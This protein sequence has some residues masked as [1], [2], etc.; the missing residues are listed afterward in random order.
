M[1]MHMLRAKRL[2]A[3]KRRR[4]ARRLG[5]LAVLPFA[6]LAIGAAPAFAA[7]LAPARAVAASTPCTPSTTQLDGGPAIT[8]CGPA[9][10][11]LTIGGKS[12]S[13][14]S[15][16]C[17]SEQLFQQPFTLSLGTQAQGKTGAGAPGN[18][19]KPF[20]YLSL[21][22][23]K[24][25]GVLTDAYYGGKKITPGGLIVAMGTITASGSSKGT[26]KNAKGAP[27]LD[28]KPFLISGSWN[29]HGVFEKG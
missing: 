11:T 24:S 8:S 20:F 1:T 25:Q 3:V 18:A 27:E 7:S 6:V 26:F 16:S 2:P 10:A 17:E 15:G 22:P 5:G 19:G 4:I 28:G 13:F 21:T 9:T 29:C 23:G 12:Y 14:K